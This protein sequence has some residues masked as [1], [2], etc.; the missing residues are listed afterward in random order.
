M[1]YSLICIY[2]TT[3]DLTKYIFVKKS[4]SIWCNSDNGRCPCVRG[5]DIPPGGGVGLVMILNINPSSTAEKK[6][7]LNHHPLPLPPSHLLSF[8]RGQKLVSQNGALLFHTGQE[9][10]QVF[11]LLPFFSN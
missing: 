8:V 4:I 5:G 11:F 10:F 1:L 2:L 9:I 7:P 3:K 6:D